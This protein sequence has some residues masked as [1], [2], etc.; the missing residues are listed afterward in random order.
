[1]DLS[2]KTAELRWFKGKRVAT[3]KSGPYPHPSLNLENI[4]TLE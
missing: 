2:C 4:Q 3:H 1:M